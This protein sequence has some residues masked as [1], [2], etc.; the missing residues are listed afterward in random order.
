MRPPHTI[1]ILR[2][3]LSAPDSTR[4]CAFAAEPVVLRHLVDADAVGV[5]R[6]LAALHRRVG[7][8][9]AAEQQQLLVVVL[10]ADSAWLRHPDAPVWETRSLSPRP[11]GAPEASSQRRS[12]PQAAPS[13]G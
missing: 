3:D 7:I 10:V 6:A 13:S 8:V 5:V 2:F 1:P 12:T 4:W 11:A 9:G